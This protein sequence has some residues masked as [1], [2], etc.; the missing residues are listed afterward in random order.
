MITKCLSAFSFSSVSRDLKDKAMGEVISDERF[1]QFQSGKQHIGGSQL[2]NQSQNKHAQPEAEASEAAATVDRYADAKKDPNTILNL[3]AAQGRQN[4]SPDVA[5]QA[6]M[7]DFGK[8]IT[9]ESHAATVSMM[10]D[11]YTQEFGK[12]PSA[13]VLQSMV[14]DYLI[15]SPQIT[16]A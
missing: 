9:P 16:L 5:M 1:Q 6:K 12:A 4:V 11:A 3:M 7:L 2:N 8:N 10:Q 15:G 13:S 14:D